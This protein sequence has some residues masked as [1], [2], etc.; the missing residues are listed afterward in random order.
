VTNGSRDWKP[1]QAR[2]SLHRLLPELEEEFA[3]QLEPLA[4][5]WHRFTNRLNREWE[6]LFSYLHEL[7]G[8]QYDFHYT[9]ERVLRSLIQSWLARPEPLR[10]LD[11][12]REA[13]PE[14][15][16]SQEMVGIVLYVDLFSDRLAKLKDHVQ[17]LSVG[18]EL[19]QRGGLS[20]DGRGDAVSRES[21]R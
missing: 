1:E 14:W 8:W 13:D 21:R 6:R 10:R 5:D 12:R 9:L 2:K 20:R 16:Q 17:Q 11:E 4:S 7:Y 19:R 3:S 15:F 18:L